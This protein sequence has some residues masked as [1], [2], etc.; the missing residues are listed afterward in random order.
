M[1]EKYQ[2]FQFSDD[3]VFTYNSV[4]KKLT[5]LSMRTDRLANVDGA[6][7]LYLY[8]HRGKPQFN[9]AEFAQGLLEA[10]PDFDQVQVEDILG[11]LLEALSK[12]GIIEK[13]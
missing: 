12:N 2:N 10:C 5:L 1:V 4:D 7:G 3:V 13:I 11:R 6:L 9:L 8:K